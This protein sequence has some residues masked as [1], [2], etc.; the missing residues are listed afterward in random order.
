M[1]TLALTAV[2]FDMDGTLVDS[3]DL[4]ARAWRETLARFGIERDLG[5]IRARIGMG[6]DHLLPALVDRATLAAI[7]EETIA[8]ARGELFRAE[9]LPLVR[10][11]PGAR[12]LILRLREDGYAVALATSAQSEELAALK[13]A[14]GIDD[15]IDDQITADDVGSSKPEPDIFTAAIA[16]L[17][18]DDPHRAIVVG[19]SPWDALAAARAQLACIGV[20]C[21]GFAD[22]D[23]RRV[24]VTEIYDDPADLLAHYDEVFG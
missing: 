5:E 23:L 24:G 1:R 16:H 10:G 3:V 19:D 11:F 14:A 4:H 20:R 13:Q 17:G 22:V 9:Y 8:A 7:G 15:L 18:L 21:G 6:G 2:L 12:E